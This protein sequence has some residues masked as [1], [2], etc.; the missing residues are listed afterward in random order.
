M[1]VEEI[2]II[3]INDI[4]NKT[5]YDHMVSQL[6]THFPRNKKIHV[7]AIIESPKYNGV[8]MAHMV[9]VL[10]GINKRKPFLVLE[11][12]VSIDSERVDFLKLEKEIQKL[13]T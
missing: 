2:V 11:D 8:S 10:K 4:K 12:D 13:Y 7:D 5:R 3:W 9:A 1:K 6:E